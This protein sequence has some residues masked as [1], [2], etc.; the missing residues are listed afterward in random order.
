MS[1]YTISD[2][3][4]S[5]SCDK[6]MDIFY[7]WNNYIERLKANWERLVSVDDTVVVPGDISWA[8]K[9]EDT[10]ADLKFIDALPGKKI[11]LKGNHDLWWNTMKKNNEFFEKNGL[12]T[13]RC[14]F[15][16]C[17]E[18][19]GVGIC[20]SRGWFFDKPE[21]EKKVILR[22]AGRLDTSISA[23]E[24]AGLKPIVFMHYPPVYADSKC[25]EILDVLKKH[26]IE[27]VY[28]GHIHG[29]GMHR[30]VPEC[31]G[32]TFKLVSCDCIDFTP[33]RII[34]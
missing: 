2:L 18:T 14:I 9:L 1:L 13:V 22:E 23:A 31:D 24:N 20:G 21:A 4:L 3:H 16:S 30:A 12:K 10:L 7:G 15:N 34:L 6:P 11:F 19:E 26:G 28:H 32:I 33:Y 29:S 8:L 27:T 17:V 5:L 25:D